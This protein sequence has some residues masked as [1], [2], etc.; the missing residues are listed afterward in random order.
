V[1]D[2][3]LGDCREV[4]ATMEPESVDAIVTDP[5]YGLEF[6]GK[7]WD[8]LSV[9]NDLGGVRGH[10]QGFSPRTTN[11]TCSDCGGLQYLAS[12]GSG[13][14]KKCRCTSPNFPNWR[15][16]D[17]QLMQAW[18]EGWAREVYRVLKPGGHMLAFGGTRT[19]H[20]LMVAIEDAGFE[21]RDCLMWLYG[22][23]FP[24]SQNVSKMLG[25]TGQSTCAEQW[26]GWGTA[27]KPAWESLIL[28]QK[29]Y[30][31]ETE[32][33]KIIGNLSRLEAQL[34]SLL[35]AN[36]AIESLGSS[37][38]DYDAACAFA[39]WS[40]EDQRN[41]L[42][43]LCDETDTQ[44]CWWMASTCLN[45]V[46]S[47]NN[48]LAESWKPTN[49]STTGER[50]PA[51]APTIDW[52]I[53]KSCTSG[54]TPRIIIEAAMGANGSSFDALPV[55]RIFS[56]VEKSMSAIQ[57]LSVLERAIALEAESSQEGVGLSPAWEPIILARKP[58]VGTV[59]ANV[60]RYGTGA[61]N[62]DGCR[63]GVDGGCKSDVEYV[64]GDAAT[65]NGRGLN[66]QRSPQVSG[67][68][69]W[70]ANL[71]LDEASAAMLDE[72]SGELKSGAMN[73][74]Y[75]GFA[76]QGIYGE[77][78]SSPRVRETSSG[79]ASRFFYVAKAS[80]SERN[81][82]LDGMPLVANAV[83]DERPSGGMHERY[84]D[85]N[86]SGRSALARN[87]HPTVKPITLMRYLCRLITPPGGLILDP[88]M[89]SGSTGCAAVMEGFSFLGIDQEEENIP[90]SEA[91]INHWMQQ[92][93]P[94]L[95]SEG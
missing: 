68:G 87:R 7:G 77:G 72:Q 31:E 23:G 66:D 95:K 54:L 94:A 62:I 8:R 79:G 44:W 5:P 17:A 53:L 29:P 85:E 6:M 73:G 74:V 70:P 76:T 33:D 86:G 27:L 75:K 58:L 13:G 82:G 80:S 46:T 59:V 22:T 43:G 35:P 55:A 26:E 36:F 89:G 21:I 61:L 30:S 83:S 88:F 18:H 51:I 19:H 84:G 37:S 64:G 67:L 81:A 60:A 39:R 38:V 16:H 90:L 47:W 15:A 1:I 69:R 56:A 41:T 9:R 91:R 63:I 2:L 34:W 40:A 93:A 42:A 14:R 10:N 24:K 45:T 11:P 28:A 65:V 25:K 4:M 52:K 50:E 20:R 12:E 3:R 57:E 32:R 48:T 92:P 71:I 78:G 49:T